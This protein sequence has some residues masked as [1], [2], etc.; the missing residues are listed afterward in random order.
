MSKNR[1]LSILRSKK[2]VLAINGGEPVLTKPPPLVHNVGRRELVAVTKVIRCGPLSGFLGTWSEGFFGGREVRSLE[3]AFAK[4]FD[5]RYAVSF[6]SA[7]T[8]LHAALVALDIGPGDEVIVPSYTMSAS[9]MAV[10]MNGAV[11]IFA[12]IDERTFNLDPI[13][14]ERRITS[15]TKAI[16]VVNL[17]GQAA[18][19]DALL[20]IARKHHLKIIEDNAQSPGATWRGKFTGTIGDVGV[21]SFN[22]HKTIQTGEGGMLVTNNAAYALRAQLCRNH[23]EVV[24]DTMPNYMGGPICG[25]NYRMTEITA[26]MARVQ[27]SRLNELN[28]KRIALARYLHQKIQKIPG[29][30]PAYEDVNNVHVYYRFAIK[31]DEAVVGISRDRLAEAMTAEGFPISKGY[32]KPIYLL[33]LFQ[34]KRVFKN[35]NFPFEGAHYDGKL[36]YSEGICPVAERYFKKELTLTDICQYPHTT[37]Q[38]DLFIAALTK[39]LAHKDEIQ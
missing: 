29:I 24:V 1:R 37:T 14:V 5:V 13:S 27:L 33:S 8:A 30:I 38:V 7:T 34:K 15:H 10:L 22:V 25:S 26:A 36:D 17:F 32:V 2:S 23:G 16:M 21:F 9:A 20:L 19:F 31:V 39:V 18:D 6:N 11:P 3:V 12:D 4:K 28:K 35:T